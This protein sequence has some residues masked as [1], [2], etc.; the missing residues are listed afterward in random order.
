M[1]VLKHMEAIF[2]ATLVVVGLTGYAD[3]ATTRAV[4]AYKAQVS[5]GASQIAVVKVSARRAD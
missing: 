4:D 2:L 3:A 1:N 5:V